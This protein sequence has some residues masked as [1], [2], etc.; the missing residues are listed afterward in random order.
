MWHVPCHAYESRQ[1]AWQNCS[2]N[3]RTSGTR[4]S[5]ISKKKCHTRQLQGLRY[6]SQTHERG[7]LFLFWTKRRFKAYRVTRSPGGKNYASCPARDPILPEP[8]ALG[9]LYVDSS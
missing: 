4:S 2:V 5:D 8:W 6:S 1:L 9:G 7:Y 3:G